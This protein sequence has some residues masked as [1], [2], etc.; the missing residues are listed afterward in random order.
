MDQIMGV[1][2]FTVFPF[3]GSP[4]P[5]CQNDFVMMALCHLCKCSTAQ[6]SVEFNRILYKAVSRNICS[7]T[8]Y[9]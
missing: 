7:I 6:L 8:K 5:K 3:W 1:V 4:N 2:I 9:L